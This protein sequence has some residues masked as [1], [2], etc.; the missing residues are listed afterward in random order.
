MRAGDPRGLEGA[1]RRY[2]DR[3]HA[4]CRS[5]LR[6]GDAAADVVHDTFLIANRHA[7]DIRDP[8]RLQ[9]WL[10][11][12][13]RR[14]CLRALRSRRRTA[15]L[16]EVDEPVIDPTDPGRAIQAAQVREL[17][18]TAATGLSEGD[19][20]LIE[21][22]VRQDL[23]VADV[24]AVLG[25]SANHAHARMS[26]ARAQLHRSLGALLVARADPG[27]CDGLTELIR[28]WD[29]VFTPLLRKRVSRHIERCARCT[30]RQAELLNPAH[31]L[32]AYAGLPFLAVPAVVWSRLAPGAAPP[33]AA[34][35]GSR[36]PGSQTSGSQT[37]GTAPAGPPATVG[38]APVPAPAGPA[39]LPTSPVHAPPRH[40]P[41]PDRRPVLVVAVALLVLAVLGAGVG[42][43]LARLNPAGGQSQ[44]SVDRPEPGLTPGGGGPTGPTDGPTTPEPT[45]QPSPPP[46][47][48]STSSAPLVLTAST[49]FTVTAEGDPAC[50][51]S[52]SVFRIAVTATSNVELDRVLL[53]WTAPLDRDPMAVSGPRKATGTTGTIAGPNATWW[54][55]AV[56][57]D[58]REA[59]TAPVTADN[60]CY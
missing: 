36:A 4:Y 28:G 19:R 46:T 39:P 3:L 21:L 45:A 34:P 5:L 7:G 35:P 1:Y 32:P 59:E 60:P 22:S 58:G 14:E 48:S 17:V 18:A 40:E 13:A 37:P 29:G 31:L 41:G 57:K 23:P 56:A 33:G 30:G 42:L 12:V 54:I 27:H 8:E 55:E 43:G 2:A 47:P 49:V 25:I 6:D 53:Y 44:S 16:T 50:I 11:T 20:E 10:Y 24:A 38:R 15:P 51:G 9:A 52:T 26:R